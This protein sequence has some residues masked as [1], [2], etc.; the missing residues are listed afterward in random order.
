M[1]L[2]RNPPV[3][4]TFVEMAAVQK[5]TRHWMLPIFQALVGST[6]M[7]Y[8]TPNLAPLPLIVPLPDVGSHVRIAHKRLANSVQTVVDVVDGLPSDEYV[9]TSGFSVTFWPCKLS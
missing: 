7:G 6:G 9:A 4:G 2:G 1:V 3:R 8:V 5:K